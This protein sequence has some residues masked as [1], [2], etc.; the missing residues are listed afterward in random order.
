MSLLTQPREIWF[1]I[2][3]YVIG[4]INSYGFSSSFTFKIDEMPDNV[5][6]LLHDEEDNDN[7]ILAAM[8]IMAMSK[9]SH[10][11]YSK[12]ATYTDIFILRNVCKI[13]RKFVDEHNKKHRR[14][15]KC[16]ADS[17]CPLA[18]WCDWHNISRFEYNK[19]PYLNRNIIIPES[20]KSWNNKTNKHKIRHMWKIYKKHNN[21]WFT[22]NYKCNINIER[23]WYNVF[24]ANMTIEEFERFQNQKI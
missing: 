6:D 20:N 12:H 23:Y 18:R 8:Y 4:N 24:R 19:N 15:M 14:F 3:D 10:N 9:S 16:G 1:H 22:G 2:I 11:T 7:A 5:K 17:L 21:P 13:A